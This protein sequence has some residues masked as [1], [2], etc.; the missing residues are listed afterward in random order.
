MH[1]NEIAAIVYTGIGICILQVKLY[2]AIQYV[3]TRRFLFLQVH[4]FLFVYM[5]RAT[6]IYINI[7]TGVYASLYTLKF[8]FDI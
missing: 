3:S 5:R 2:N 1:Y 7:G 6:W 4:V 8:A